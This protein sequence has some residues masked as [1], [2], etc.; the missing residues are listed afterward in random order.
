M[1]RSQTISHKTLKHMSTSLWGTACGQVHQFQIFV[2]N[3]AWRFFFFFFFFTTFFP[4]CKDFVGYFG[5][6]YIWTSKRRSDLIPHTRKHMSWPIVNYE[7]PI[8]FNK[9]M[10]I[11]S[12]PSRSTSTKTWQKRTTVVFPLHFF[13]PPWS[14]VTKRL[15]NFIFRN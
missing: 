2:D 6:R 14:A 5:A 10:L 15:Q 12:K 4:S 8:T 13:W 7:R 9:V 1:S 11:R 3:L